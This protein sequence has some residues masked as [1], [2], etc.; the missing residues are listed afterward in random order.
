[1]RQYYTA[2]VVPAM[3]SPGPSRQFPSPP[4]LSLSGFLRAYSLVSSRS[5][6]V[7]AYHSLAMVPIADA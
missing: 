4:A 1:M 6:L 2:V 7:D 3:S 5:F